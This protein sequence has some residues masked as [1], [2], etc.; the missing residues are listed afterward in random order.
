MTLQLLNPVALNLAIASTKCNAI[1]FIIFLLPAIK[2]IKKTKIFRVYIIYIIDLI[3]TTI[4]QYSIT[5]A[6]SYK[7]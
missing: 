6:F 7:Y 1:L 2:K 3:P 5:T 4:I